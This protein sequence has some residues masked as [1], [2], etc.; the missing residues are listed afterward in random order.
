M[1][2][3]CMNIILEEVTT[4]NYRGCNLSHEGENQ[5]FKPLPSLIITIFT[6]KVT[7]KPW[8]ANCNPQEGHIIF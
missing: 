2:K 6:F 3:I 5:I 4:M 8:L 7:V 1:N